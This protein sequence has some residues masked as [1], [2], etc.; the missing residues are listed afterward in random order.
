MPRRNGLKT[1]RKPKPKREYSP[2]KLEQ[3]RARMLH[4]R[5]FAPKRPNVVHSAYL[6]LPQEKIDAAIGE[7]VRAAPH[8][9]QQRFQ[10]GCSLLARVIARIILIDETLATHPKAWLFRATKGGRITLGGGEREYMR[11]VD[12]ARRL[13]NDLGLTPMAARALGLDVAS[14]DVKSLTAFLEALPG[15][16]TPR[17]EDP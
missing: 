4:A 8:L 1:T 7:L 9:A 13:L 12:A 2:E 17:A 6:R 14:P 3:M 10:H 15:N 16:G 11:W 5:S